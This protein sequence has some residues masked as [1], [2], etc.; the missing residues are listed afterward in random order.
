MPVCCQAFTR[1]ISAGHPPKGH[2]S[3]AQSQAGH[4]C[5]GVYDLIFR[6]FDQEVYEYIDDE[7]QGCDQIDALQGTP[8]ADTWQP[9]RVKRVLVNEGRLTLQSDF[10]WLFSSVL[11]MR[12]RALVAL[13]DMLEAGGEILPL[14]TDDGVPLYVLNVTRIIDAMDEERSVFSRFPNGLG[15]QR[16]EEYVFHEPRV[17][18]VPFFRLPF[19]GSPIFVDESFKQRVEG[20]GLVG[21]EFSLIW[22]PEGGTVHWKDW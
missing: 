3:T 12:T 11:I 13:R 7:S 20:A 4:C 22:S 9:A 15:I 21:L 10:P 6:M 19:P 1:G 18:D 8:V 16:V 5:M 17:R 14:S 2:G